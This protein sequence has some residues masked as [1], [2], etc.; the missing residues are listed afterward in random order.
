MVPISLLGSRCIGTVLIWVRAGGLGGALG[1]SSL[2]MCRSR[3]DG[4]GRKKLWRHV[5]GEK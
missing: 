3:R 4:S 2:A 1:R 5:R